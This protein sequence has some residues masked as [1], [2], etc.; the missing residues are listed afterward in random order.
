MPKRSAGFP[1]AAGACRGAPLSRPGVRQMGREV[2]GGR[3]ATD[4]GVQG[5]QFER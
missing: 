2:G 3:E 4:G 5:K 1:R